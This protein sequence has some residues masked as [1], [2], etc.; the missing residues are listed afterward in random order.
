MKLSMSSNRIH[1]VRLGAVLV[2]GVGVITASA[3]GC[4][5]GGQGERCNPLLSHNECGSGLVCNGSISDC[6]EAYCCPTDTSEITSDLC[7]PGCAGGA[8]A[9]ITASCS[10]STPNP[11]CAC[12][13]GAPL[14]L[15]S[16]IQVDAGPECACFATDPDPVANCMP[17]MSDAGAD[18]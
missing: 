6:P 15:R 11:L 17:M 4:N 16:N 13:A 14:L 7:K 10:S 18:M 5:T 1:L 2:V 8:F 3:V 12:F 9:E